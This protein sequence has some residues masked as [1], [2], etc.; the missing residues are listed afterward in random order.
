MLMAGDTAALK[1]YLS[2]TW[3][4]RYHTH[5]YG[6]GGLIIGAASIICAVIFYLHPKQ[7]SYELVYDELLS[8]VV[9]GKLFEVWLAE[10]V[11]VLSRRPGL[12]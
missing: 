2:I 6:G 4:D 11:A 3:W 10:G 5:V 9:D 7:E 1:K 12:P 8:N